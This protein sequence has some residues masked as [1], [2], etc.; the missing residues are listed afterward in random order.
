MVKMRPESFARF[1]SELARWHPTISKRGP[2]GEM[3]IE[4]GMAVFDAGIVERNPAS[5][6]RLLG[7]TSETVE[8]AN[9]NVYAW[10]GLSPSRQESADFM[11]M[12]SSELERQRKVVRSRSRRRR[13]REA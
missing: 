1:N 4:V 3:L 2:L 13:E 7:K 12:I 10:R 8:T 11:R 6:R 5:V 9:S